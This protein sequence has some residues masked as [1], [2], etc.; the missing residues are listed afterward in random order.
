MPL[1]QYVCRNCNK[2]FDEYVKK[3]TDTVF[4]PICGKKAERS[5]CGEMLSSTGKHVKK[6]SGNCKTC[7]GC[8]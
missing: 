7:G 6:C 4:C 3:Y 8:K 5:F 2:N 1:L